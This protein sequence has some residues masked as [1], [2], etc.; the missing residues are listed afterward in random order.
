MKISVVIPVFN[1]EA[2]VA[3]AV[4]SA[5][6]QPETD[7]VILVED[8]SPDDSFAVCRN[9]AKTDTRVQLFRH[10][11]GKNYGAAASRNLGIEKTR[12]EYVA[13]LDADDFYL[14]NR[15]RRTRQILESDHRAEAVYEA[16]G[17]HFESEAARR[18]WQ[19]IG[20]PLLTRVRPG[21]SERTIFEEQS[22]IGNG[23][24]CH[25]DGLTVKR[26]A[27]LRTGL[28]D[29]KLNIVEDTAFFIKLSAFAEIRLGQLE[30]PVAMRRVHDSN[31][32]TNSMENSGMWRLRLALWCSTLRWADRHCL[33][34]RKIN[35][36]IA[37]MLRDCHTIIPIRYGY[38]RYALAL[39]ERYFALLCRQPHLIGNRYFRHASLGWLHRSLT[40]R[41]HP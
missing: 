8:G 34:K 26:Q 16:T 10:P 6:G 13:F 38:R 17:T 41:R 15:F 31:R 27:L 11:N 35:L 33:G 37:G 19:S 30:E 1:A 12:N 9:L 28:F 39:V 22:P 2:Y 3:Q 29:S 21:T 23:G 14:A 7:Q 32:V 18:R 4:R 36:I 5:L 40:Q 24:H 25:L 20:G